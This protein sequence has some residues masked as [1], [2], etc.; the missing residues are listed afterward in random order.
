MS[1]VEEIE[2][3][4]AKL[5]KLRDGIPLV[6]KVTRWEEFNGTPSYS[7]EDGYRFR[8]MTNSLEFGEDL[9]AATLH[10]TLHATID[11][12]LAIL[13]LRLEYGDL[14]QGSGSRFAKVALDLARAIN[15]VAS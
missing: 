7:V 12:Q 4:K 1:A 9:E 8:G 15:G 2:A 14:P 3:A 13:D 6:Q 10:V 5:T 11:A